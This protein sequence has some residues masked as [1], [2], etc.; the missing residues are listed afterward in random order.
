MLAGEV[1]PRPTYNEALA[2]LNLS[3]VAP[4]VV[5]TLKQNA[6]RPN[7]DRSTAGFNKTT[8]HRHDALVDV[9]RSLAATHQVGRIVT[10][11]WLE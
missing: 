2:A 5:V 3:T 9:L 10:P 4:L 8:V 1:L 6:S 11:G 7:F